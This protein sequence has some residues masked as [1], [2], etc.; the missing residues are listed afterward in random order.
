[1]VCFGI[2]SD[3][4]P[5]SATREVVSIKE[6]I[7]GFLGVHSLWWNQELYGSEYNV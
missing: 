2:S 6:Q 7:L 5:G 1:M 3:E 4:P